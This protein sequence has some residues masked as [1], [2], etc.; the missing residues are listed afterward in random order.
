MA[1][2]PEVSSQYFSD[3][4]QKLPVHKAVSQFYWYT[5]LVSEIAQFFVR[6]Q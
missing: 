6:M 3:N 5:L 2:L 1:V 4:E